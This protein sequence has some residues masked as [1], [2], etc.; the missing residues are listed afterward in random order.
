MA[1]LAEDIGVVWIPYPAE[2]N[3]LSNELYV[4]INHLTPTGAKRYTDG[5]F[6]KLR[7]AGF[8]EP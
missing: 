6:S 3:Y 7:D 8:F 2:P 4:D 5:L 1:E